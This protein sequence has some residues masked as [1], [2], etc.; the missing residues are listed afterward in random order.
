ME[1]QIQLSIILEVDYRH[2]LEKEC[3]DRKKGKSRKLTKGDREAIDQKILIAR[4]PQRQP[5]PPP[6]VDLSHKPVDSSS[7]SLCSSEPSSQSNDSNDLAASAVNL[8]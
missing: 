5:S 1:G 2:Y 4:L 8:Q 7:V 6:P 3:R